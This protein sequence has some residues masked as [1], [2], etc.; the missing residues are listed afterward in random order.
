MSDYTPSEAEVLHDYAY[1][2]LMNEEGED[3][4]YLDIERHARFDR[5]IASVKAEALSDFAKGL[6]RDGLDR[7]KRDLRD[8]EHHWPADSVSQVLDMLE[9]AIEEGAGDE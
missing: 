6:P 4:G 2:P 8:I 1:V 7:A 5:S 3:V 9:W